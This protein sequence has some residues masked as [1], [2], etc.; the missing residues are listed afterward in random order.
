ML[1]V[2]N[3][4]YTNPHTSINAGDNRPCHTTRSL[5][6]ATPPIPAQ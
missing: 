5:A 2:T 3:T 1:M 4:K 6:T